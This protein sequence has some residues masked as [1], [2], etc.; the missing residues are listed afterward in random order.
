MLVHAGRG[1][2]YVGR[3]VSLQRGGFGGVAA[4]FVV[5]DV[6]V[7][8]DARGVPGGEGHICGEEV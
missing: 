7:G 3:E 1:R 5:V 2:D 4:A 8:G 6:A